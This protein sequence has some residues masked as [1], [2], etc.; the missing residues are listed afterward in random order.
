MNILFCIQG[1]GRGHLTQA[2]AVRNLLAATGHRVAG[3]VVGVGDA[4]PLPDFF[5]AAM[6]QAPICL[7]TLGF[8]FQGHRG[9]DRAGTLARAVCGLPRYAR[10]YRQLARVI[11]E[12]RPDVILNF[13]EPLAA[14]YALRRRRPP[15]L[16]IGHQFMFEHPT[17]LRAPNL[18]LEQW[19][20]KWYVRA[21]GVADARLALSLY[22]AEDLPARRL[23]VCPPLL[24]QQLFTL[25]PVT[26]RYVLIYLL[27]HGY[28]TQII[29]WHRAHPAVPLHCFY[30][31]PGA[32]A[33]E[34][35]DRTLTFHR[36]DG[37]K[38]LR[39]MAGCRAVVCTAGFESV[40]EAAW[41]GKPL[42]M[43][44]VENHVEQQINAL[45]AV[46]CGFGITDRTFHL[47]RLAEL[48]PCLDNDHFRKWVGQARDTLLRSITL[49]V[50]RRRPVDSAT[51]S[52]SAS[53]GTP[54]SFVTA[55]PCGPA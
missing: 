28:A 11:A 47:D 22:P 30:D 49:A 52:A 36:L 14:M 39:M 29:Q 17:Y 46:R 10:A 38:F 51:R 33:E 41:L 55:Q 34:C 42:F 6:G 35:V 54:G 40:S 3:V 5:A 37:T 24:R 32:P 18:R 48:P 7:P 45:D 43:V 2:M 12:R 16:A 9:V 19:G 21:L 26:G 8:Q 13:F 1:E 44:P 4:R 23:V 20:M 31:K 15:V 25:T 50:Q 27:N 53:R